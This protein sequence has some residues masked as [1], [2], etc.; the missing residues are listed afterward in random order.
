[1]KVNPLT[2]EL[3]AVRYLLDQQGS[4]LE[5][6]FPSLPLCMLVTVLFSLGAFL[7]AFW[8]VQQR[9]VSTLE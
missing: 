5:L 7:V 4:M 3:A 6:E 8:V 9:G 2:Y 1:M